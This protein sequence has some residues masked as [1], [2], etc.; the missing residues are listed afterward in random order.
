EV[1]PPYCDPAYRM[2]DLLHIEVV[3]DGEIRAFAVEVVR[4]RCGGGGESSGGVRCVPKA[5]LGGY[6]HRSNGKL[7]HHA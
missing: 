6:R 7:Y 1:W 4:D 3:V 5:Y 2:P